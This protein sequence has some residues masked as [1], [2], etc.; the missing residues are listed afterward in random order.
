MNNLVFILFLITGSVYASMESSHQA[1]QGFAESLKN[2]ASQELKHIDKNQIP[3]FKTDNPPETALSNGA[4]IDSAM[5]TEL[6]K[7]EAGQF[8]TESSKHHPKYKL[9]VSSDPLFN[10][11]QGQSAEEKLNIANEPEGVEKEG[12]I[13]KTCQEGGEEISYECYE[14][15]TVVPNVPIKQVTLVVN[16]L[17]FEQ[18]MEAYQVQTRAPSFWHHSEHETRYR[19]KGWQLSLPVDINAFKAKF[20]PGFVARDIK[21]NTV[22]NIDCN[23][24]SKYAI[25]NASNIVQSN[26]IN[27]I[28]IVKTKRVRHLFF[29]RDEYDLTHNNELHITLWHDTY[30]GE[31]TDTWSNCDVYEEMVDQGLCQYGERVLTQGAQTRNIGGHNI[32][33]DAWQYRSKFDCKMIK[34]DCSPLRAQGCYQVGSACKEN[35]NGKCWIFEQ[36]YHCPSGKKGFGKVK[37]P[38]SE[39]FCLTG[40]CHDNSYQAN[41][42][43]LDVMSKLSMLKEIQNDIRAQLGGSFQIFKGSDE[44]CSRDCLSFK[45]CCGGHKGWGVSLRLASCKAEEQQLALMRQQSLC[46]QVGTFCSKKFL[47]KCVTKKTSFCCFKSKFARFLQEQG[48]PQLHM[49]F[50]T[51]ECPDCRGLSVEELSKIDFT[52]L[53]FSE[54]FEEIMRKYQQSDRNLLPINKL[55]ENLENIQ[56]GLRSSAPSA[57]NGVVNAPKEG[58]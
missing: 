11:L 20:C 14:N 4:D 45:D 31:A 28:E 38:A 22:Y 34:D 1:G 40:N 9:D 30:E 41:G 25:H 12:F 46:H 19:Q 10:G 48:R 37:S 26:G 5:N 2:Q 53:D 29:W 21:T 52:T 42:D 27:N 17:P 58:L 50:G 6:G 39:A 33:K 35:R 47:G 15:R 8:L 57:K 13:E 43:M 3:G 23:R 49:G 24:I 16:H 51:A 44:R 36:R 32:Y 7:S 56:K 55:Q 54:F 18:I